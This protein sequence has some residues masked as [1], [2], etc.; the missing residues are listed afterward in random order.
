MST[1]VAINQQAIASAYELIRPHIRR[2]PIVELAGQDIGLDCAPLIL[3]LECLQH[4]GSFKPRGAFT[5]LLS[6]DVP[7]AGVA[8]A[9]GGNHGAA[10]AYAASKLGHDARI[11]VPTVSPPAKIGRIRGAG[12]EIVVEGERYDHALGLCNAY[13]AETGALSIHAYDQPETLM[14]QGTVAA[15]FSEQ[16]PNLDTVLIAVGGGGLIGGMAAWFRGGTKIVGVEPEGAP[17]LFKALEAGQP[18]DAP[19]GSIAADSLAPRQVG[20]LMYPIAEAFVDHVALVTDDAIRQ[21]QRT[22][23]NSLR[24]ITEPG[25]A[26]AFAALHSGTYVPS[27]DERVGVLVC[28]ANSTVAEFE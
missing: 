28:G 18:V 12:A 19:T 23:W 7:T 2:T 17:T 9:S 6:R 22:L 1:Q 27:G 5:N 16:A 21:A 24:I 4:T 20:Q 10:V 25:G 8:A 11:F 13:V 26:A 3:K 14:G 15:E